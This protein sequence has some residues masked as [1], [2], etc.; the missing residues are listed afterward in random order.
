MPCLVLCGTDCIVSFVWIEHKHV[1]H[2]VPQTNCLK[3][4]KKLPNVHKYSDYASQM[5]FWGFKQVPK[6]N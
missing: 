5:K 2:I 6:F 4:P 1:S 3:L